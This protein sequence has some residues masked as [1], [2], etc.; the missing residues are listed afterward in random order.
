MELTQKLAKIAASVHFH[1]SLQR[2]L[3][4]AEKSK[5]VVPISPENF[6]YLLSSVVRPVRLAKKLSPCASGLVCGQVGRLKA[7]AATPMSAMQTATNSVRSS[8]SS[9]GRDCNSRPPPAIRFE[10]SFCFL[11]AKRRARNSQTVNLSSAG[12]F[13]QSGWLV[14]FQFRRGSERP[15]SC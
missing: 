13:W 6:A 9:S 3:E 8:S 7:K 15:Q 11:K 4:K 14:H 5:S 2:R 1:S 10:R 12:G